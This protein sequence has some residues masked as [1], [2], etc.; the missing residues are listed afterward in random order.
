MEENKKE[1]K[2]KNWFAANKTLVIVI[3]A[4]LAILACAITA[5]ALSNR[6]DYETVKNPL[7]TAEPATPTAAGKTEKPTY[8]PNT[9]IPNQN[10]SKSK[11]DIHYKSQAP[12]GLD[13]ELMTK[14]A[15][16]LKYLFAIDRFKDASKDISVNKLVQY[17]FCHIYY[18]SLTDAEND[19]AMTLRTASPDE[20]NAQLKLLFNITAAEIETA[21][22]YNKSIDRFEMWEP[23]YRTEIFAS[24][25]FAQGENDTYTLDITFYSDSERKEAKGTAVLNIKKAED[26]YYIDSMS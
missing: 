3:L 25:D 11:I 9:P 26:I 1:N 16:E 4:V 22:L 14:R 12:D 17:A 21:D 19:A 24:A 23:K 6:D 18:K 2:N 7:K 10:P 8:A 15:Y 20:I 5:I 13:A